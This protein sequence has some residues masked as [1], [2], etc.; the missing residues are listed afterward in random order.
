MKYFLVLLCILPFAAKAQPYVL[1]DRQLKMP[2]E[3]KYELA[4]NK[5]ASFYFPVHQQDLD[6]MIEAVHYYIN[7]LDGGKNPPINE[8][9]KL[10]HSRMVVKNKTELDARGFS[11]YLTTRA[12]DSG[13][14]LELVHK[15]D[16]KRKGLQKMKAFLYY[17][18]N[19]RFLVKE[20]ETTLQQSN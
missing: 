12:K 1:L 7:Y 15:N 2:V 10:G 16:T 5:I 19:N 20:Q 4:T 9:L 8:E 17:L 13:Y 6:A 18:R 3:L 14:S 11:I